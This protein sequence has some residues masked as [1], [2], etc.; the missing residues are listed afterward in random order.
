[1]ATSRSYNDG[2]G[3]AHALD[4][5][6]ERW[7]MLVVR[8]LLLGPK[9]YTDLQT[10]LPGISTNVLSDRLS[11]LEQTGV[12]LRRRLPPPA[13]SSVYEL[14]SWGLELEPIL[15]LLGRWGARSRSLPRDTPLSVSS[16]I[17]SLGA[18]FDP[19]SAQGLRAS[20]ELR[21]GEERFHA[22]VANG[23]I[24]V[25]RG[26]AGRPIATIE[27]DTLTLA[28]LIYRGRDLAEAV[29]RGEVSYDGDVSDVKRFL[30]LFSLPQP[31]PES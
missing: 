22:Q 3:I 16:L 23:R 26:N 6:G 28:G 14:T 17:L 4:L 19:A 12:V 30:T 8:E 20:Y 10:D 1:V 9:R 29:R 7:A 21:L 24:E 25:T 13:A 11:E 15:T 2:C 18:H 5:V 27:G 31:A